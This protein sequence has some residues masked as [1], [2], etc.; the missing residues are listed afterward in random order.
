M[1]SLYVAAAVMAAA[2]VST[3]LDTP[4]SVRRQPQQVPAST[5][6]APGAVEVE[7]EEMF[8]Q[9]ARGLQSGRYGDASGYQSETPTTAPGIDPNTGKQ[10]ERVFNGLRFG[11]S[12]DDEQ[13]LGP[14]AR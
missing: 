11:T 6:P 5:Q 14:R 7:T 9:P 13:R 8:K 3:S 12:V 10:P 2:A 1:K 4:P